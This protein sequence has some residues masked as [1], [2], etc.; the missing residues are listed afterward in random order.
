MGRNWILPGS[1]ETMREPQFA[2]VGVRYPAPR[3]G[4]DGTHGGRQRTLRTRSKPH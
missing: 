1:R 2:E 4:L 3:T